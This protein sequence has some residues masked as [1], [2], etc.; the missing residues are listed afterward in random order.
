MVGILCPLLAIEFAEILWHENAEVVRQVGKSLLCQ[1]GH[2]F[3]RD[4][5]GV[6]TATTAK[7]SAGDT[8]QRIGQRDIFQIVTIKESTRFQL[9]N[10]REQV[11]FLKTYNFIVSSKDISYTFFLQVFTWEELPILRQCLHDGIVL[12]E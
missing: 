5:D 9:F 1:L 12:E 8:L 7:S 10:L 4:V 6:Q 3:C 11:E 2:L